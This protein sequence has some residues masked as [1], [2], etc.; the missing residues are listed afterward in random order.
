MFEK[1]DEFCALRFWHTSRRGNSSPGG[2]VGV[3]LIE[4]QGENVCDPAGDI[5]D[6]QLLTVMLR[7]VRWGI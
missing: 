5:A 6:R 1:F 3:V 4:W 2:G 7:R